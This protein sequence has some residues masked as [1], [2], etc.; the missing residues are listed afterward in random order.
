MH[1]SIGRVFRRDSSFCFSLRRRALFQ[2]RRRWSRCD[3]RRSSSKLPPRVWEDE[4]TSTPPSIHRDH[5]R[6]VHGTTDTFSSSQ[7]PSVST[8]NEM[9]EK[10]AFILFM[11]GSR[12]ET[13]CS[14]AI[15]VDVDVYG[16]SPTHVHARRE[17]KP[18]RVVPRPTRA[19]RG[20]MAWSWTCGGH[21]RWTSA[22]LACLVFLRL[23]LAIHTCIFVRSMAPTSYDTSSI[24]SPSERTNGKRRPSFAPTCYVPRRPE[25][26]SSTR[27]QGIRQSNRRH[28]ERTARTT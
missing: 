13:R 1:R 16:R 11:T 17:R 12:V 15:V 22:K 5:E 27:N 8:D 26:L 2:S 10:A 23:R 4:T 9:R 21:V 18:R 28:V 19:S 14:G 24:A 20:K 7:A 3:L 6:N 25:H